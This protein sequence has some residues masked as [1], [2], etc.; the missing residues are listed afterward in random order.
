VRRLS[1][2]G[3][4]FARIAL[5]ARA[6]RALITL[7]AGAQFSTRTPLK[8]MKSTTAKITDANHESRGTRTVHVDFANGK[9]RLVVHA[10]RRYTATGKEGSVRATGKP[11]IE[12]ATARDERVWIT[13]D[14]SE[15]YED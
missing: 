9:P 12:L 13:L 2:L 1:F 4:Q 3:P 15:L 6:F 14:L 5:L 7:F 8:M 10:H 11:S